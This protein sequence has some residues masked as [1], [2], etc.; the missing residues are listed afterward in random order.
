KLIVSS[1]AMDPASPLGSPETLALLAEAAAL[2]GAGGFRV[3]G[4]AV[5]QLLRTR[6]SLPIIGIAKAKTHGFDNYI[7]TTFDDVQQLVA[8]GAEIIAIQAT[9]GTRPGPSFRELAAAAHDAG[10]LVMADIATGEEAQQAVD[11]GANI[12][13]TTMV[14]HTAETRG[15]ARPPIDLLQELL[16]LERPVVVE[17]GVWTPEHVRVSFLA[18]AHAV[19]CGSAITAPDLITKRLV[20]AIP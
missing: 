8:A 5:V 19:V 4:P 6:S 1:Q 7:T 2:G 13:A 17:G 11:D 20:A 16:A 12:I 18:G 15:H 10:A 9:S 3:D 14:G